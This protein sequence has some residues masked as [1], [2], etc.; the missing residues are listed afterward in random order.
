MRSSLLRAG[1]RLRG[2]GLLL[3]LLVAV[4]LTASTAIAGTVTN[5]RPLIF[6]FD[7]TGSAIGPFKKPLAIASDESTGEIYAIN[8]AGDTRGPT[9]YGSQPGQWDDDR[10]VCRFDANGSP[11]DFTTGASAGKTCLDGEETAGGAFGVEGF[12]L[13]ESVAADIAVD[14]SGGSAGPGEG[15]Q[16]RLYLSE[17]SGPVHA[18]SPTGSW[19]WTLPTVSAAPCGIAVDAEGH[20]WVGDGFASGPES[21]KV[22]EFDTAAPAGSPPH[23]PPQL[24][25]SISMTNSTKRACRLA[26][27]KDGK[28]LFVGLAS[29]SPSGLDKYVEGKYDSSSGAGYRADVTVDQTKEDGHIFDAAGASFAEHEPCNAS[30]CFGSEVPG[31]PFGADLIGN[32]RGIAYSSANDWVYISDQVSNSIKVFGPVKSGP[33]PDVSCQASDGMGLHSITAHCTINPLVLPNAYHFEWKEGLGGSWAAAESSPSQSVEPTDGNPHAVSFTI[34]KYKGKQLKSNTIFQVR[35]VGTDS[36]NDLSAYSDADSASTLVPPPARVE[37]CDITAITT[38]SS[39]AAC[40]IDP[41]EEEASWRLLRKAQTHATQ[42]DCEALTDSQFQTAVT[43]IIAAEEPA[44]V[45]VEG[46]LAGLDPAQSYCVRAT[47]E[48]SGGGGRKDLSFVTAAIPPSEASAAFAAP[49]TATAARI[50]ARVNPN[51]EAALRYRFEWSEDGNTW[52]VLPVSE[53]SSDGREPIIISEE[54]TGLEPAHAYD[55]RLG[56]IENEAGP[57]SSLGEGRTFT[58]RTEAELEEASPSSCVVNEDVRARQHAAYLGA[59]RGIELVNSPDKGNQNATANGPGIHVYTSSP[60]S[61]DGTMVLW[62]VVGGAPGGPNGTESGFLAKRSATGWNSKSIAPPAEEQAGEG[63]F[64]YNLNTATPDFGAFLFSAGNSPGLSAPP[65]AT[66]VRVKAG[67]QDILK[68]YAV[69]APNVLEEESVDMSNDGEHVLAL[70]PETE[71]LEDIGNA[72]MG[73]PEEAGEVIS[74]MP[75]GTTPDCGLDITGGESFPGLVGS[76]L[77]HPGN[78]WIATNDAS[79]VFFRV[80]PDGECG[81]CIQEQGVKCVKAEK[82]GPFGLY[83]R[84]REVGKTILI[85]PNAPEFIT[86]SPDG[87]QAYFSTRSSLDSADTDPSSPDLYRWDEDAGTEGESSCLTCMTPVPAHLAEIGGGLNSVLISKDLSRIYFYSSRRVVPGNGREG[88]LNLY[89]LSNGQ[90]HFVSVTESDVLRER[91][92]LSSDGGVLLFAA[93]ANAA[94]T[95]DQIAARCIEPGRGES[96]GQC[97]EVYRY[98]ADNESIECVSCVSKGAT[99]HSIGSPR[100]SIAPGIRLSGDGTTAAFATQEALVAR[101]VNLDTDLYEWRSGTPHLITDG[102]SDFQ[103]GSSAPWVWGIDSDGSDILF[104]VVPPEGSLTGFERDGLLNLYDARIGGGFQPPPPQSHCAEDS[105]QGPLAPAPAASIHSSATYSGNGNVKQ[106]RKPCREGRVRR[107]GHCGP[108]R[109]KK[110][111]HPKRATHTKEAR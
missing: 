103:E 57:A 101:D 85:D 43:G 107:E 44:L 21:F 6:S 96:L 25:K 14:N 104:G 81:K 63:D 39:H 56:L 73:P 88:A 49:R 22:L 106:G 24:I 27:D 92:E 58:T 48:N 33:V 38:G 62:S 99:T 95:S 50:N 72:R 77:G 10:V 109:T 52:T 23:A 78:H 55:Y 67:R 53:S 11:V 89:A 102:I 31:S 20:L 4:L 42:A 51:G 75:D 83:V 18:F 80:R 97:D 29:E 69:Q 84:N 61:A 86:A 94:L 5:S 34:V 17:E 2:A 105:C 45:K 66:A 12:L 110:Q 40:L 100:I 87:H 37:N 59:C 64:T 30:H 19:L 3:G 74:L 91:A 76:N 28:Q 93:S 108:R 26:L 32:A 7:G 1:S 71:Q 60:M 98:E 16:G 8:V 41:E 90:V 82:L 9:G 47:A 46:D 65:P 15:E 79:R 35:L 36:E 54:L 68:R 13:F 111:K 70:N